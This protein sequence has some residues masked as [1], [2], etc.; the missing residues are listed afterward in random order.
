MSQGSG[1]E[2]KPLTPAR[3]ADLERL[4]GERGA[5]GGCWCMWWRQSRA[6]HERR[7]GEG[8][9]RALAELVAS[10]REPG[11]LAY[12]GDEPVGWV[13]V[14]PREVY[15]TL[16]RSRNLRPLDDEPVWS[17]TCFFVRPGL[18]RQG[19]SGEL[20]RAAVRHVAERG[21]RWV[22]GY[23]VAP[24]Q[25][26]MPAVFAWTG[27]A[28]TFAAAGFIEVARRAPTRPIY[29]YRIP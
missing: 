5:C 22:E 17:V 23:P 12:D 26:S 4:F 16:N 15:P 27:L 18:R 7:K 9:R 8:N 20:L 10:G 19:L 21:G 14:E 25:G 24:R 13:A 28:A 6:E 3:F 11:I 1:L 29:R 2:F